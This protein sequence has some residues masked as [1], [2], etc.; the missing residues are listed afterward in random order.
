MIDFHGQM[1][2]AK[3]IETTL[4]PEGRGKATAASFSEFIS[5]SCISRNGLEF[6]LKYLSAHRAEDDA[7]ACQRRSTLAEV[8]ESLPYEKFVSPN[9]GDA[10]IGWWKWLSHLKN[11][12]NKDNRSLAMQEAAQRECEELWAGF[13]FEYVGQRSGYHVKR[14]GETVYGFS[15]DG[16]GRSAGEKTAIPFLPCAIALSRGDVSCEGE[17]YR[18]VLVPSSGCSRPSGNGWS[19]TYEAAHTETEARPVYS[20]IVNGKTFHNR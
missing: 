5:I 20:F 17:A 13:T 7:R 14:Y 12:P 4:L 1:E 3:K 15:T 8:L 18:T 11:L 2:I 6:G 16:K 10:I 9:I 19:S